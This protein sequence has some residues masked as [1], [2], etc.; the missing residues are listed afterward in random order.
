MGN[1]TKEK[2]LEILSSVFDPE[3]NVNV[4]DLG[5]IYEVKILPEKVFVLMTLTT[6]TCPYGDFLVTQ[7][8]S[9]LL[10]SEGVK[11]VDVEITFDP[12]WDITKLSENAK[13]ELGIL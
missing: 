4:V 2:I 11:N 12:P 1:L 3:I 10:N 9:A 5:L 13:D 8:E 6:P 7:L